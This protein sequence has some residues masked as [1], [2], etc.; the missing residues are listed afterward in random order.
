[1]H[2][3]WIVLA[4]MAAT[5]AQATLVAEW[6][7]DEGSGTTTY[8]SVSST[9]SDTVNGTWTTGVN[10]SALSMNGTTAQSV[11]LNRNASDLGISGSGAKTIVGWFKTTGTGGSPGQSF[12][13]WSP[14]NG[15]TAG[16]DLRFKTQSGYLRFEVNSGYMTNATFVADG[17]WHMAAMIID[18]ND[19]VNTTQLALDGKYVST[20][21]NSATLINTVGSNVTYPEMYIGQSANGTS[22]FNGSVDSVGIFNTALSATDIAI[23]NG[24]GRIGNNNMSYLTGAATLWAGAVGDTATINGVQWQK[25]SGLA[26]ALGD[27]SQVGGANGVDSYMVLDGS[28][29][30]LQIIPEP[31]TVGLLGLFGAAAVLRRRMKT[32]K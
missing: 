22:S 16:A 29:N 12:W 21:G 20:Y 11:G 9:A 18:A 23:L 28:G 2:K 15:L 19:V 3:K 26:G 32:G 1:M 14:S 7:L 5:A 8:D 25:V 17:N 10:S 6:R 24:L 27:W 30:G 13:G 4:T 31:A